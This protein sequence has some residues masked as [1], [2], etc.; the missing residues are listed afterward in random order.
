M[1]KTGDTQSSDEDTEDEKQDQDYDDLFQH[2]GNFLVNKKGSSIPL[3]RNIIDIKICT[4][5]NKEEP[6]QNRIKAVEFHP[7]ARVILTA[8]LNQK[9]TLFQVT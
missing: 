9:L 2:T 8:G 5:A 4:D 7:S 1:I 6:Q 3:A